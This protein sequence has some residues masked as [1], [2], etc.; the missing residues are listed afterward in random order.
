MKTKNIFALSLFTMFLAGGAY[1]NIA[2]TEYVDGKIIN[3]YTGNEGVTTRAPS[4]KVAEEIANA[5]VDDKI[6]T[7]EIPKVD[8]EL[9]K[10]SENA[11]ENKAVTAALGQVSEALDNVESAVENAVLKSDIVA[12]LDDLNDDNPSETKVTSEKIFVDLVGAIGEEFDNTPVLVKGV[13]DKAG[14]LATV[15]SNGQYQVSDVKASDLATKSDFDN[16]IPLPTGACAASS[17]RCVLSVVTD[18]RGKTGLQWID[19]LSP[20]GETFN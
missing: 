16:T 9:S 4:V 14:N 5:V 1:A 17:G 13:G 19:I 2:G 11:I 18:S 10:T 20:S 6:G 7:L 12:T 3:T 8:S 15:D